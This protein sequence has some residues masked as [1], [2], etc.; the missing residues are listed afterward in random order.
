M[1]NKIQKL[2][3]L[4]SLLE[5]MDL[6]DARVERVVPKALQTAVNILICM[7][8][9]EDTTFTNSIRIERNNE[10]MNR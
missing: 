8:R 3:N 6:V 7:C 10:N 2:P 5:R 4:R 1:L 9:S